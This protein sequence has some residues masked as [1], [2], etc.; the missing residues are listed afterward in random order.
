MYLKEIVEDVV[1]TESHLPE[2]EKTYGVNLA[3]D[4]RCR[5]NNWKKYRLKSAIVSEIFL[6]SQW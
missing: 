4:A 2:S 6:D 5:R 3:E 1:S